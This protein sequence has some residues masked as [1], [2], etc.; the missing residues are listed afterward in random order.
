MVISLVYVTF[1]IRIQEASVLAS[2]HKNIELAMDPEM[3]SQKET[4]ITKRSYAINQAFM[5][6]DKYSSTGV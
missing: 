5:R 6:S 4:S 1:K 2:E 3:D